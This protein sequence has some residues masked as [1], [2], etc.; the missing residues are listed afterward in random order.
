MLTRGVSCRA[1]KFHTVPATPF[2]LALCAITD[3]AVYRFA[4]A[5]IAVRVSPM[6]KTRVLAVQQEIS[7]LGMMYAGYQ[8]TLDSNSVGELL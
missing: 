4:Q 2:L 1:V 8:G 6:V 7:G 5:R 3:K